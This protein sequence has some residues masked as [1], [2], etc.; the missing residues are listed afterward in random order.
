MFGIRNLSL[1]FYL[2]LYL[3]HLQGSRP[4]IPNSTKSGGAAAEGSEE[5]ANVSVIN[6]VT[7]RLIAEHT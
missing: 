5:H 7:Q 4:F 3:L 1:H 2:G 6:M